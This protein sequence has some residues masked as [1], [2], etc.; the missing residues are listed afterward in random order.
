METLDTNLKRKGNK[1][2]EYSSQVPTLIQINNTIKTSTSTCEFTVK[3]SLRV[4]VGTRKEGRNPTKQS[5][6]KG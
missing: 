5:L 4:F 1:C 6:P 2:I 3:V